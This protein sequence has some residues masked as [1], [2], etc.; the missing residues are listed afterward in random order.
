LIF[1]QGNVI[2]NL[3]LIMKVDSDLIILRQLKMTIFWSTRIF[4]SKGGTMRRFVPLMI[5]FVLLI[6]CQGKKS[7]TALLE[8]GQ[9]LF[10]QKKYDE[11]IAKYNQALEI[12]PN[13]AV[14]YNLLGMAYRFKYNA[15]RDRS[16]REKEI[17]AFKKAIECDSTYWIAHIN[18]ASTYYYSGN[19]EEAI[20]LFEKGLELNPEHPEKEQ[21][22][23]M[24]EE[25]KSKEKIDV[26]EKS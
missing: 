19:E 9:K 6:S 13:S 11:A 25:F 22:E 4:Y 24:I 1:F 14:A 26:D 3:L 17:E 2:L 23:K 8:E 10:G 12:S 15:E 7:S 16:L 21:I 5:A 20:P 18:L